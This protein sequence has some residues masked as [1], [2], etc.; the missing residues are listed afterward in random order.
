MKCLDPCEGCNQYWNTE[1]KSCKYVCEKY[2]LNTKDTFYSEI[3]KAHNEFF[4]FFKNKNG[5]DIDF[6]N[7]VALKEFVDFLKQNI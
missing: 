1:E 7:Q 4:D 2:L 5:K 6:K 3:D